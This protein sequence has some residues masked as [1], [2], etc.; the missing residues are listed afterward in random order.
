MSSPDKHRFHFSILQK[1]TL[2]FGVAMLLMLLRSLIAYHN[3]ASL[4]ATA[5]QVTHTRQVLEVHAMLLRDL[6][7]AES[8]ERG[9]VIAGDSVYLSAHDSAADA[10][11]RDLEKLKILTGDDPRQMDYLKQIEP[12]IERKLAIMKENIAERNTRGKR[13]GPRDLRKKRRERVHDGAQGED[14]FI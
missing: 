5:G 9:Y 8:A 6:M 10:A 7:E 13:D 2:G 12:L 11:G 3:E 4:L 1:I 14:D